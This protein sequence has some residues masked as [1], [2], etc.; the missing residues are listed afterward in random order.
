MELRQLRYF[1]AVAESGNI[2]RAAQRIFLTQP[3]LSRQIK[4]LE[5]E[6]G[7]DLLE[8]RANSVR[9]TAAGE[10]MLPAA[11]ALLQQAERVLQRV[12]GGRSDG[13]LRVG[14]APAV[15]NGLLAAAVASFTR[16]QPG[17]RMDMRDLSP[18]EMR[19]G[20]E[21]D[22]LDV[23]LSAG[24][25]GE[26]GGL[27]WVALMSAHWVLAVNHQHP[28][29]RRQRV[30]PADVARGPLL[31]FR[32]REYPDYWNLLNS[33]LHEHGLQPIIAGEYDGV[34]SLMAAVEAGLGVAVV[35][36]ATAHLFPK[37][38]HFK[39]FS[40]APQPLCIV[41]GYRLSRGADILL[42]V[43]VEELRKAALTCS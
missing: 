38:A 40:T 26:A 1:V 43:F 15:C 11:R 24:R 31:V 42:A 41:A 5:G 23:V 35:T 28:L 34:E 21:T 37:R 36:T 9:L 4:A 33:W 13:Q 29:A 6:I 12:R 7:R 17:V 32:L 20:L 16:T 18:T 3:A 8:R 19:A 14:Y 39:A 27:Q 22:R 10:L 25:A 30:G 2:S